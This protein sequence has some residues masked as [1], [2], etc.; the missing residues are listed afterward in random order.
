[1]K[2]LIV[3][4]TRPEA[5]K[6][7]PII[8]ELQNKT[9]VTAKVCVTG[10]HRTM[11]DQV[12]SLFKIVPDYDL[13]IM[14]ANQTLVDILQMTSIGL[15][16]ILETFEAN[17]VIVQGDTNTTFATALTAFYK[18]IQVA[19]IEAGL[20]TF[21]IY[22]PW[23]E[24]MNR[25]LTSRIASLH[26]APTSK[27]KNN[28][29]AEGIPEKNIFITGNTG[30]DTLLN[31]VECI[32][33][34]P[35]LLKDLENKF[36][37]NKQKKIVLVTL[38]RRENFGLGIKKVCDAILKLAERD[39]IQFILPVHLNPNVE[40]IVKNILNDN[41]NIS[42]IP[43]QEYL[44]F[45]Y[46]MLN[47]HLILTDSGGI[48]EEAPTLGKPVLVIRN[49]TERPEGVEKGT[50]RVVGTE[51]DSIVKSVSELLD[52]EI[53]YKMMAKASNAYGDGQAS[54]RIVEHIIS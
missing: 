53:L 9:Q 29:L 41:K 30:I 15:N 8:Y 46:L 17:W 5:I 16:N 3:F 11:L 6:L 49:T 45:V 24:E 40:K 25:Q 32:K 19:H 36:N 27:A 43:P 13:N 1:M 42:L 44:P 52:N 31:V 33:N 7:A 22:S 2:I 37:L 48:Q 23:P 54:K 50:A 34:N 14:T 35:H 39:D 21:D 38:H 28:L 12:L 10:Q 20:R 51:T 18:K 26:F 47:S 4:G